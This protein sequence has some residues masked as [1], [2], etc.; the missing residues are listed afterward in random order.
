VLE[1]DR[2]KK[3]PPDIA[4]EFASHADQI[5]FIDLCHLTGDWIREA[6][7]VRASG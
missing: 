7:A 1:P 4:E 2:I 5:S 3:K 6:Y